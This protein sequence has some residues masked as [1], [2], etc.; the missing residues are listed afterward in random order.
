MTLPKISIITPS[1]NQAA[2][3]EQNIQSVMAQEYPNFEHIIIDGGS[4]DGTV[5]ILKKYPHLIWISEKDE[6]QADALNKGLAVVTGEIVGWINSDDYYAENCFKKISSILD[7]KSLSWC[8]SHLYS[9]DEESGLIEKNFT[10]RIT[11][12]S[13]MS[14]AAKVRQP[15]SF[16]TTKILQ[17]VGGWNKDFYMIMDREL[18]VRLARLTEPIVVDEFFAYF[19]RHAAQ[20]SGAKNIVIQNREYFRLSY[21]EKNPIL[22]LRRASYNN[23]LRSKNFVKKLLG[24]K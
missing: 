15:G 8:A 3:I 9:I 2:Y 19:R 6:G 7:G 4:Q 10:N 14:G 13:L 21:R 5:E 1:F 23:L 18:W 12:H 24:F 20:K 11:Y 17:E 22:F 16:Y